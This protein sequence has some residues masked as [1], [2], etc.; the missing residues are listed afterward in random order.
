MEKI[1]G[2]IA[3]PKGFHAD[4]IHCGLKKRRKD[5]GWIYSDVPAVIAGVFTTNLVQAAPV[6]Y[7]KSVVA[8]GQ[9]QAV[10][11][12]SG[13]ANACTGAQG[14]KDTATM[15]QLAGA[16]LAINPDLVAV[17]STGVIGKILPMETVATGISELGAGVGSDFQQAILTTDTCE[18]S[19]VYQEIIAGK[20]V[21][22]AGCGK[23]SG[24]IHPNMATMLG[25]V[26]TDVAI[27]QSL[28]QQ[29]LRELTE[30]TFNQITVDGDTSTN[31]MVLILAN[32]QAGNPVIKANTFEY[33]QFKKVLEKVLTFLAKAIA[34]DGEG[35]TKLIE[36]ITTGAKDDLAARMISKT[37]VGSPLV[38]TAIFGKDPNWGRI[39]CAIGYSGVELEVT[40]LK[41]S[42]GEHCVFDQ[43][44]PVLFDKEAMGSYLEQPELV[45]QVKLADGTGKGRA[46]GCDLTYDYVK[47]N[48]LY[49]T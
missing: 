12:N 7:T 9:A 22:L 18:K 35:A 8:K 4:G 16:A 13:N 40:T 1:T 49:H 32:G 48:A 21:T 41:I 2:D 20:T 33:Q 15:A 5:I 27:E 23:G 30:T 36:V 46:W 34:K 38:K 29:V 14:V 24:M 19:V 10:V 3:S 11:V 47:I 17:A 42:I 43:G 31:D 28:L 26:T 45:I 39:L 25:F 37:V 6:T 44:T